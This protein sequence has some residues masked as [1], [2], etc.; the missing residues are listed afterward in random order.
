MSMVEPLLLTIN[1]SISNKKNHL[2][3][4]E[5]YAIDMIQTETKKEEIEWFKKIPYPTRKYR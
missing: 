5:K 4:L 1:C 2:S 3:T